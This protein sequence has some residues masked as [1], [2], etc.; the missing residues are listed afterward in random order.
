MKHFSKLSDK[1]Q[2]DVETEMENELQLLMKS[3]S[4][5]NNSLLMLNNDFSVSELEKVITKLKTG[6]AAGSDGILNEVIVSTFQKLK[7]FWCKLFNRILETGN[8]Q[9]KW[10]SGL[11]VPIYKNKGDITDPSNY[12]GIT[13]LSCSAKFFTAVVNE[14]LRIFF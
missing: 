5:T 9:T 7:T 3:F 12:R 6:K 2:S 13:L 14:R 1:T 4:D 8:I 10:F 11:I